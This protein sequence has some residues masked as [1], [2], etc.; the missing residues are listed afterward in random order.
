[1]VSHLTT[2][3]RQLAIVILGVLALCGLAMASAGRADPLGVHGL[4]VVL[5]SI[6]TAFVVIA[7]SDKPE[8]SRERLSN[9]YDDPSKV[10]I[11]LAMIWAGFGNFIGS[12]APGCSPIRGPLLR[13]GPGSGAGAWV[14]RPGS[15]L[16]LPAMP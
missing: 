2:T 8:P 14:R 15:T 4:I 1:M 5:F 10:G 7:G 12:W 13:R 9:Y 11:I 6:A 16:G 3:E